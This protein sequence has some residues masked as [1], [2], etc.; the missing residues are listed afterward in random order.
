M[1]LFSKHKIKPQWL[2][3]DKILIGILIVLGIIVP[4]HW[5][6]DGRLIG[7][8]DHIFYYNPA[9]V[10]RENLFVWIDRINFGEPNY[11]VAFLF[12]FLSFFKF[13]QL[14][15][16]N[17]YFSEIFWAIFLF[18][19]PGL[20]MFLLVWDLLRKPSGWRLAGAFIAALFY[21]FNPYIMTDMLQ[22]SQRPVQLVLPLLVFLWYRGLRSEKKWFQYATLFALSTLLTASTGTAPAFMMIIPLAIFLFTI[23]WLILHKEALRRTLLFVFCA[24][25]LSILVNLWWLVPAL[26][27][28]R[29]SGASLQKTIS[30]GDFTF[31]TP[32]W[33]SLR[34]MGFWAF[35]INWRDLPHV[36]YAAKYYEAPFLILSYLITA[37]G[38]SGLFIKKAPRRMLVFFSFLFLTGV[39]LSKGANE[40]L[41]GYYEFL[42]KNFPPFSMFRE[43][44]SKITSLSLFSL[45]V[46]L[47][48]SWGTLTS[49][50]KKFWGLLLTILLSLAIL[51]YSFPIV[52][53]QV[54][55]N[56]S[57]HKVT[58]DSLH[59]EI[60][61]AWFEAGKWFEQN[62]PERRI[63][64]FP[65]SS[66]GVCYK[67]VMGTC[68]GQA[69][70]RL[71]LPNQTIR[72]V[73]V[74]EFERDRVITSLYDDVMSGMLL[75][76]SD[77]LGFLGIKYVLQQNDLDWQQAYRETLSPK[78]MAALLNSLGSG[79]QKDTSFGALDVYGLADAKLSPIIFPAS[80]VMVVTGNGRDLGR[81][82]S[83]NKLAPQ[84]LF[85]FLDEGQNPDKDF[86][87]PT[88]RQTAEVVVLSN[89][90]KL[91]VSHSE[92]EVTFPVDGSYQ[93]Y[94]SQ[95]PAQRDPTRH[96]SFQLQVGDD[97]HFNLEG[98]V[99]NGNDSGIINL[100]EIKVGNGKYRIALEGSEPNNLAADYF[101]AGEDK[102]P[103]VRLAP[104]RYVISFNYALPPENAA[105]VALLE[106][107]CSLEPDSVDEDGDGRCDQ[108]NVFEEGLTPG[109]GP[110]NFRKEFTVYAPEKNL[111]WLFKVN[112]PSTSNVP[113]RVDNLNIKKLLD[114]SIF[115]VKKEKLEANPS[116][117]KVEFKRKSPTAYEIKIVSA[118]APYFLS[119]LDSFSTNWK[120]RI[121]GRDIPEGRHF[122]ADG[123]ANGWL[124]NPADAGGKADYQIV[125]EYA[126]QKYFR[127]SLGISLLTIGVAL[128]YLVKKKIYG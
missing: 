124:I 9:Y 97:Y 92:Y 19:T 28:Y 33:E 78:E 84:K 59:I 2:T 121:N 53:G 79:L 34:L 120:L 101:L 76:I 15:G 44:F 25:T 66:Y 23:C 31:A 11:A 35:R 48:L 90:Q 96:G 20:F 82:A 91:S 63:I 65:K 54:I 60:P 81:L 57:W 98:S 68:A 7:G 72:F 70:A 27:A 115:F 110:L 56:P 24:A 105:S 109:D 77:L 30:A 107:R 61:P 42:F 67:W 102:R 5:F 49:I 108:P 13:F 117:P 94:W 89:E 100:G 39:F 86:L 119:F 62:D 122:L 118:T 73:A 50:L 99:V 106:E 18:L 123:F 103:A 93:A 26:L 112:V 69:V 41:G 4:A 114:A 16:F 1:N 22:I 104:G 8:G 126:P 95:N 125:L 116:A 14:F 46:I 45:A 3:A 58:R 85:Y 37:L 17:P 88:G 36:P 55:Q 29:E 6:A 127:W 52:T 74:S 32:L 21:M 80:Q 111:S 38:L 113:L 12:P 40:P 128:A 43:P 64:L 71:F 47:G 87:S 75:N 51:T 10:F 83:I